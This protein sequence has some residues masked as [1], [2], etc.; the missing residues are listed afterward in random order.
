MDLYF[1]HRYDPDTPVEETLDAMSDLV[2]M[3]K[4]LYYGVSEWLPSQINEA[5]TVIKEN[6]FKPL[7]VIQPQYNM[8]DRFIEDETMAICEKYGIGIVA[9]SPLAQGLLTGKYRKGKPIP[10]GSR[11]THQADKQINRLL[12][13]ENLDKVEELIKIA[14]ELGITMSQLALAWALRKK[15][16]TSLIIGAS[17]SQQVVDNAMASG[18]KLSDDVLKRIEKILDYKPFIRK[19][20]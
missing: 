3:G 14:D 17:K 15:C 7:S 13:D 12:T 16:M 6:H 18:I 9:F 10:E 4:V 8:A 1:C 20:G 19:I 2:K 11:A 5:M